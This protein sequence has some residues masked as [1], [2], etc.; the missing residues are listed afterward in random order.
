M[1]KITI[2]I[3]TFDRIELLKRA[4]QSVLVQSYKNF[5]IY[6]GNDNP[7]KK[8]NFKE[9]GIKKNNKIK[10]FNYKK[11]IGERGNLNYLL[12]KCKTDFF[13]WLGDDDY[14]HKDFFKILI[15]QFKNNKSL[16]ASYSNY[17]R[18]H[19]KLNQYSFKHIHF[20]QENFLL[21]FSSKELRLIGTFGIIKTKYLKKIGGI[22]KTGKSFKH[23]GRITHHYP[24][25]DTLIPIML[26]KYG[27]ISWINNRLVYLN[28]DQLS[29]SG[30][31]TEYEAYISAE[32]YIL[33]SLKNNIKKQIN[34]NNYFKIFSNMFDLFVFSRITIIKKRNS[35]QN[36]KY[37]ITYIKDLFFLSKKRS[38]KGSV[39]FF[40]VNLVRLLKSIL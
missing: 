30:K 38:L 20:D 5:V 3:V 22:N 37:L 28:T 29:T 24:Y 15:S 6:I 23:K 1:K 27:K 17:S 13:C 10:I 39:L 18:A 4:V 8:I 21:G 33:N 36:I 32:N 35:N 16:V 12:R 7:K 31:T 40:L 25:C 2:G 9:L 19:L 34:K 11:N 26:S 14:L